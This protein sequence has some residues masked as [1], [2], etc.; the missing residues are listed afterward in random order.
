MRLWRV[1]TNR[2]RRLTEGNE[3]AGAHEACAVLLSIPIYKNISKLLQGKY[4]EL[5]DFIS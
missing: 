2:E 4:Y 3:R 1:K 5:L